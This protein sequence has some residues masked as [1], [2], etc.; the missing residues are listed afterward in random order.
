MI[1]FELFTFA[2]FVQEIVL[3][4]GGCIILVFSKLTDVLKFRR[5]Q[6]SAV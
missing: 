5:V 4:P 3:L 6:P 1:V 2:K